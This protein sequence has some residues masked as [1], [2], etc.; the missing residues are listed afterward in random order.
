MGK[1]S[2]SSYLST[3]SLYPHSLSCLCNLYESLSKLVYNNTNIVASFFFGGFVGL[4]FKYLKN[5]N[6]IL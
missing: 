2:E 3:P 5:L 1:A 6:L 4:F